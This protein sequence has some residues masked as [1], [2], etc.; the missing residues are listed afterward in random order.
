MTKRDPLHAI[1]DFAHAAQGV[2]PITC[3]L[4]PSILP[5]YDSTA[6]HAQYQTGLA[7]LEP[8]TFSGTLTL[9]TAH[10]LS[11]IPPATVALV[12]RQYYNNDIPRTRNQW[13][14]LKGWTQ[15]FAAKAEP[16]PCDFTRY[17]YI[18]D[19]GSLQY[20]FTIP[21]SETQW[22]PDAHEFGPGTMHHCS[23]MY[24]LE[25]DVT[26][27]DG[28]EQLAHTTTMSIPFRLYNPEFLIRPTDQ[29]ASGWFQNEPLHLGT[30][31]SR[32]DTPTDL[33]KFDD[34]FPYLLDL[35]FT[36]GTY[37]MADA[38][39]RFEFCL[40]S[41]DSTSSHRPKSIH[42]KIIQRVHHPFLDHGPVRNQIDPRTIAHL[43][44]DKQHVPP[45]GTFT[46]L[47]MPLSKYGV[48]PTIPDG[49]PLKYEIV[50]VF[51]VVVVGGGMLWK[52]KKWTAKCLVNVSL[53]RERDWRGNGAVGY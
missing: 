36:N 41:K 21:S 47:E 28:C 7:G 39:P 18:P 43:D 44:L 3:V 27:L 53:A 42:F 50:H 37:F 38:I 33:R 1:T 24:K 32:W 45:L 22:L 30:Y 52:E 14:D 34:Y 40:T 11:Y 10:S 25:A 49:T 17:N 26:S 6:S 5:S 35:T 51:E 13:Q 23:V 31:R 19:G 48:C 2:K 15:R 46:E 9:T 12:M 20:T 8:T 4:A 29:P 16:V